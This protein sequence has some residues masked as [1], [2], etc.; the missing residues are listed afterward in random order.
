MQGK[1]DNSLEKPKYDYENEKLN[2][3]G[4]AKYENSL[5]KTKYVNSLAMQ[6]WQFVGGAKYDNS[7]ENEKLQSVGVSD[8]H[9][10]LM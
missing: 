1:Y 10:S 2:F 5:A 6:K 3:V 7:L 9:L 4:G 8:N